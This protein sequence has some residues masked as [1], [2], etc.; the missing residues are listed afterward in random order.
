MAEPEG[1]VRWRVGFY[2]EVE[3]EAYEGE[4]AMMAEAACQW[5]GNWSPPR[6]PI[7]HLGELMRKPVEATVLRSQALMV[8]RV[9]A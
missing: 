7:T 3:V 5:P 8:K 9:D 1:K 6:E 2:V 4:A